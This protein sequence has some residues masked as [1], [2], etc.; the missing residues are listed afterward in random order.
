MPSIDFN[1]NPDFSASGFQAII[2]GAG[3]AGLYLAHKLAARMRVLVLESG[4]YGRSEDRQHLNDVRY[5]GKP[6]VGAEWG[7]RRSVGGTTTIWGGQSLPFSPIDFEPRPWVFG[8]G[9]WPITRADLHE[10]YR[11]AN[12]AMGIDALDYDREVFDSLGIK[13]LP[14]R[15][16]LLHFHVSKWAREPRFDVIFAR[17]IE[18]DFT[19]LFNCHCV[20]LELT[21]E[22]VSAIE[23]ANF[24]GARRVLPARAVVLAAGALETNR[25]LLNLD[26]ETGIFP[27]S[28]RG[29]LGR[30]FMDHVCID[31]G[32]IQ[33]ERPYEFQLQLNTHVKG[34]RKYSLR[35]STAEALQRSQK[36]LNA[37]A[38]IMMVAPN[39][40]YFPYRDYRNVAL[41]ARHPVRNALRSVCAGAATAN[42]ILRHGFIYKRQAR[43]IISVMCEQEPDDGSRLTLSPERD[44]FGIPKLDVHWQISPLT[45]RTI[46][47]LSTAIRDEFARLA[48]GTVLLRPEMTFQAE[49]W[50]D[51]VCDVNHHMG[52]TPMGRDERDSL[53]NA[54]LQLHALSNVFVCSTSVFPTGAHSNPTLTLLALADRLAARGSIEASARH[55]V[56]EGA[57]RTTRLATTR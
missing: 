52:G 4:H 12:R 20:R 44:E 23:V 43:P 15:R 29:R 37:S 51:L 41:F 8:A 46:V 30:R 39:S 50:A 33:P 53:V 28:Q 35:L 48:L 45:W 38:S 47:A 17:H 54:E 40:D 1:K 49:N 31:T 11:A 27:A 19:L 22:A 36:L 25:M 18:R 34:R 16:E 13:P 6:M 56:P 2:V 21:D 57:H 9:G 24:A 7:R 42:A 10:H 55:Y 5:S 3:A 14:F 26:A 32:E